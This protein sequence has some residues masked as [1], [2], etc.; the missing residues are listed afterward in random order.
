MP[1]DTRITIRLTPRQ[2]K[3]MRRIL[4]GFLRLSQNSPNLP[5]MIGVGSEEVEICET[6]L[7]HF[8]VIGPAYTDHHAELTTDGWIVRA[9]KSRAK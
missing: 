8:P 4:A 7:M 5:G 1:P 9:E 6:L 3:A 2:T